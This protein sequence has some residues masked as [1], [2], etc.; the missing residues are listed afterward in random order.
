MNIRR[1]SGGVYVDI[2]QKET[3]KVVTI[4]VSDPMVVRILT[5]DFP[6]MVT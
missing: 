3:K 4:G 5:E 6:K 1:A 2:I